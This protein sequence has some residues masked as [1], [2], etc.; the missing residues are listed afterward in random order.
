MPQNLSLENKGLLVLCRATVQ[1]ID[2][3]H[4]N[5]LHGS[6]EGLWDSTP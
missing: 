5:F 3:R 2:I 4:N 6:I 1:L